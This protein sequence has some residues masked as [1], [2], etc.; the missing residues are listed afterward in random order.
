MGVSV[1]GRVQDVSADV[2]WRDVLVIAPQW[3]VCRRYLGFVADLH[4]LDLE[5]PRPPD[6]RVTPLDARDVPALSAVDR[7]LTREEVARRLD[8]GQECTLGWCGREL[9][10]AR[11]DSTVPVYLP[12]LGRVL[13]PGPDE[14]IVVGIY[15]APAFR[16]RGI[17]R[18][19]M[20]DT[21]TRARAVGVSRWVWLAAWWNARSL[22]LAR[23][24]ESRVAGTVGCWILG[25]YR[26]YFATGHIRLEP[27]GSVSMDTA[28]LRASC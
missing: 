18:M 24:F 3:L 21:A 7:T 9:A 28:G 16:G 5:C 25:P 2:G 17:A 15:T 19:V 22:R 1:F 26:R 27:D 10:H 11:W 13:R 4:G 14:Q 12:Y 20:M 8:A 6:I 23:Q